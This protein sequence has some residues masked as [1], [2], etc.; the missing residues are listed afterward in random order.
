MYLSI[1][2]HQLYK[3]IQ[4]EDVEGIQMYKDKKRILQQLK[5]IITLLTTILG[6]IAIGVMVSIFYVS[7]LIVQDNSYQMLVRHITLLNSA[8]PHCDF[9]FPGVWPILS[10]SISHCAGGLNTWHN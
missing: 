7:T 8:C 3:K 10:R 2:A 4:G 1:K 5:P 9:A 6:S